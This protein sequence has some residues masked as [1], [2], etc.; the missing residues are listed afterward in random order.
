MMMMMVMV[1][2]MMMM[3]ILIRILINVMIVS[4][5]ELAVNVSDGVLL[6]RLLNLLARPRHEHVGH[7]PD[8]QRQQPVRLEAAVDLR[9]TPAKQSVRQGLVLVHGVCMRHR[10]T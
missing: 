3:M 4:P 10:V 6:A 7:Q 9:A 5:S 8:G 2:M 1:M